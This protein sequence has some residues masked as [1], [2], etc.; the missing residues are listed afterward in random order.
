MIKRALA[1]ALPIAF[2]AACGSDSPDVHTLNPGTYAVSGATNAQAS[3]GCGLLSTY[4]DPTKK[5]GVAVS[6]TT[7]TFNLANTSD[8]PAVSLPR[9]VIDGN[10][11]GQATE[12]SYTV[13]VGTTCVV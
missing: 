13:A 10:S 6:G 1:V 5:I 4:Q 7:A 9:A 2:L 12:A 8:A 3:D 11:I